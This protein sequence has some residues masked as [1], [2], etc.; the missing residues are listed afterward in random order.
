[1]QCNSRLRLYSI[2]ILALI[3]I[4]STAASGKSVSLIV[5][6]KSIFLHTSPVVRDGMIYVP[7]A[8]LGAVGAKAETGDD[9]RDGQKIEIV[10]ASGDKFSCK[11]RLLQGDLMLPIRDIAQELGAVTKFDEVKNALT[12]RARLERIEFDGAR[13]KVKTSYPVTY[14]LVQS[15]WT[16]SEKK[17]ILDIAGVQMPR[18]SDLKI[19][20]ST[21]VRIRT[22][23]R[24]DGETV[25]V[26]LDMPQTGKYARESAPKTAQ[27]VISIS[28]PVTGAARP[29]SEAAAQKGTAPGEETQPPKPPEPPAEVTGISHRARGADHFEVGIA[30]GKP[31]KYTT[32]MLRQPDRLVID[33]KNAKL[34][35]KFDELSV[36][37]KILRGIRV[38]QQESDIV[39]VVLDLT[40]VAAFDIK[41]GKR[42]GGLTVVVDFPRGAGGSL[43]EKIIVIDPGH[44]GGEK[45]AIGHNGALEKNVNL[46]IALRT[47]RLL[48]DAGACVLMTRKSDTTVGLKD[49]PR[50]ANRHSAD[51]FVSIHN[52]AIDGQNKISG[53]EA[54]YHA[55]DFSSR[56]LAQCIHSEIIAVNGLP[57]RKVKSDYV[58]FPG[59]GM[60][61]LRLSGMPAVLLE[62][63]FIDHPSDAA[64][65]MDPDFQQK[66]ADAVVRGLKTYVEGNPS[67]ARKLAPVE[68]VPDLKPTVPAPSPDQPAEDTPSAAQEPVDQDPGDK[69]PVDEDSD[70]PSRPKGRIK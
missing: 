27:I 34:A 23:T 9:K 15:K 6:G 44:G 39:R 29:T 47:K 14:E 40:R 43:S 56:A 30:V 25:R 37:H 3:L 4:N 54:F 68:T 66:T 45:G 22:G 61:V 18:Q 13:L 8:A 20:N 16:K 26:V 67:P 1:M 11:A 17:L 60:A 70:G 52:N 31:V 62:I 65:L 55:G 69:N 50:F 33:L 64:R 42:S 21:S 2:T 59:K 28:P 58:R 24:E 51:F 10:P 5:G 19:E 48:E 36:G 35:R 63:A 41:Q 32:Y 7:I 38:G 57:D 49:R 53:T 46:A 12:I